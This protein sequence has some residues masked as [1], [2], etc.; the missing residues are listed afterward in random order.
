M[1][2]TQTY[3][4]APSPTGDRI[5][6]PVPIDVKILVVVIENRIA[7]AAAA[8][9]KS[10]GVAARLIKVLGQSIGTSAD[11]TRER[12]LDRPSDYTPKLVQGFLYT[13]DPSSF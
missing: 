10:N 11:A 4:G 13:Q 8:R 5:G 1:T 9:K 6:R 12:K 7:P 3:L 2:K